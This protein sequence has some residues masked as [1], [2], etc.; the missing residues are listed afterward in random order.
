MSN[1]KLNDN[2]NVSDDIT[3]VIKTYSIDSPAS[4]NPAPFLIRIKVRDKDIKEFQS[5][6]LEYI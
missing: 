2:T 4:Y 3:K 1:I 5:L 6:S